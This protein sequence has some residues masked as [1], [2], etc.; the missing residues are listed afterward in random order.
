M[1]RLPHAAIAV[2]ALGIINAEVIQAQT[3]QSKPSA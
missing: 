3:P 1:R 2:L